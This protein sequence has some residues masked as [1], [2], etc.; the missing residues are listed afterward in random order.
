MAPASETAVPA[1]RL[2]LEP[3]EVHVWAVRLEEGDAVA[4]RALLRALL[5]RYTGIEPGRLV[6]RVAPGGK[7]ELVQPE[8]AGGVEFNCSS[9]GGLA[10]YAVARG[11]R[12]GID[13]ERVRAV[14]DPLALAR[15]ALTEAD[16]ASIARLP[17][18]RRHAAF[19]A[20]WTEAEAYLKAR[21]DGLAGIGRPA[22]VDATWS[23]RPLPLGDEYVGAVAAEGLGWRLVFR[24]R[25]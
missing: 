23:I 9:S 18:D 3:G 16:R 10:V 14:S 1:S 8:A 25:Q 22:A 13:V 24:H 19:L 21:G 7:P 5:A 20:R 4:R 6:V 15:S 12:V 11:R 2:P 17:E